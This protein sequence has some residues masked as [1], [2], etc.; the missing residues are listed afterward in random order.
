[1]P[2]RS[3]TRFK[4]DSNVRAS[5]VSR[6]PLLIIEGDADKLAADG[7]SQ[8]EIFAEVARQYLGV[9]AHVIKATDSGTLC[10]GLAATQHLMFDNIVF[11]GHG[12]AEGFKLLPGDAGFVRWPVLP[13]YIEAL[14][15]HRLLFIAC[16]SGRTPTARDLFDGL[17]T[18]QDI[19][20]SP[21]NMNR[22]QAGGVT[23]VALVSVVSGRQIDSTVLLGLRAAHALVTRG[24]LFHYT[25]DEHEASDVGA[26]LL[27]TAVEKALPDIWPDFWDAIIAPG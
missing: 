4:R 2:V 1:M 8:A 3:K 23:L 16:K 5:R 20:A 22:S 12:N 26:D 21:I 10:A 7:L 9:E 27:M 25:R 19:F 14:R 17:P 18:L 24:L 15:P 11:I 13:K 6:L